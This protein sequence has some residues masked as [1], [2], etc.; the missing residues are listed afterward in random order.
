MT[1]SACPSLPSPIESAPT[2]QNIFDALTRHAAKGPFKLT[3]RASQTCLAEKVRDTLAAGGVCCIEAPTGT[4]KT[5]GYLAGA[6]D[7]YAHAH[8]PLP[9]VVATATV[10]LQEQIIRY[11]VPRLV[12]AGVLDINKVAIAKGRGR[13]FCPRTTAVLED[14]KMRDGQFDL[15]QPD[16]HVSDGGTP[17]ALEMLKAWREGTW[18]GDQDAWL[19]GALPGCWASTC[20]ASGDTCVG[21]VCDHYAKCPYRLS[22]ARMSEAQLIIANQ[23]LVL[24]DLAQRAEQLDTTA[25]PPKKYALIFDEAHNLPEKAVGTKRA[26]ANLFGTD[27]LRKLEDYGSAVTSHPKVSRAMARSAEFSPDVFHANAAL[28]IAEMDH[29]GKQI[30]ALGRFDAS[31]VHHWGLDS[32]KRFFL[33]GVASMASKA[34]AIK[35]ALTAVAKVY[36]E[37]AEESVGVDKG[38]AIRVLAETFRYQRLASDLHK[39][40]D[41]FCSADELVRWASR[42]R[43]SHVTLHTQPL[44]GGRVLTSLLWSTQFPVALVSATLQLAGSFERFKAKA[45]LPG[46]AACLALPPVFDYSRGYMHLPK[47]DAAPGEAGYDLELAHQIQT[48]FRAK[49]APGMLVLFTSRETMRRVIGALATDVR[50]ALVVPDGTPVPELVALHKN[51]IDQGRRSILCGLDSM[52][53]GLDLPGKYCG[54]VVITRLPFAVPGDPVEDARRKQLGDA[55][56]NDAYL[57]DMLISLIQ[58]TGR[59]IRREDDHGVISVLDKRI[60]TKRYRSMVYAALPSFLRGTELQTYFDEAKRRGFDLSHGLSVVHGTASP[61]SDETAKPRGKLSLAHSRPVSSALDARAPVVALD[62]LANLY[63]LGQKPC[64]TGKASRRLQDETVFQQLTRIYPACTGPFDDHS[65][66]YLPCKQACLPS[67]APARAWAE[68]QMAE[69][70][71]LG[72]LFLNRT[73]GWPPEPWKQ[74]LRLRPDALQF[75]DVLRSHLTARRDARCEYLDMLACKQHL[76]RA[77][78]GLGVARIEDVLAE[79]TR[80]EADLA[81]VLAGTHRKP[82]KDFLLALSDSAQ[83]LAATLRE[84]IKTNA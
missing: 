81:D 34:L 76:G 74:V 4:G 18:N 23:D 78:G 55:W 56:F 73:E 53:E 67:G 1:L 52:A 82:T 9:I 15:F 47:M 36:S 2:V 33:E 62:P 48:L 19:G 3:P 28:L 5:L 80:V 63:K 57:A 83:P 38:H 22:R 65:E 60:Y 46:R 75:A 10:S 31:N 72:L 44:E 6:L 11:D 41:L 49:T 24:A 66:V 68:R 12:A 59:L 42:N 77:L 17:I 69:A 13:Y 20:A 79:L 51:H 26:S 27:W 30:L 39:G 40:L 37:V 29:W 54:H 25:L 84:K 7:F 61:S 14:K 50:A 8:E 70:V 16:K 43:D 64:E 21:R 71:A 58:G 35:R 32:P 45:G